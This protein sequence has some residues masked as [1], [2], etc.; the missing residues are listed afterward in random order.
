VIVPIFDGTKALSA[1]MRSWLEESFPSLLD[2][3]TPTGNLPDRNDADV[4]IA[5]NKWWFLPEKETKGKAGAL[6]DK[7]SLR[8]LLLNTLE[9]NRPSRSAAAVATPATKASEEEKSFYSFPVFDQLDKSLDKLSKFIYQDYVSKENKVREEAKENVE[10]DEEETKEKLD[11]IEASSSTSEPSSGSYSGER[12]SNTTTNNNFM[13]FPKLM[14]NNN[15]IPVEFNDDAP[16]LLQCDSLLSELSSLHY[17]DL[18]QSITDLVFPDRSSGTNTP[19]DGSSE[20]D[21]KE[22]QNKKPMY[23]A[24]DCYEVRNHKKEI[25]S[26]NSDEIISFYLCPIVKKSNHRKHNSHQW[27]FDAICEGLQDKVTYAFLTDCGTSFDEKCV[28]RLMLELFSMPDLIGVTAR[29]RVEIPNRYF[30]PCIEAPYEFMKGQHELLSAPC[31]KCWTT[32]LLSPCPLQ[33]IEFE[34]SVTI[35]LAMFNLVEA[36]PVMPGPCQLMHWQKMKEYNV[37]DE[38]F[39]LLFEGENEKKVLPPLPPSLKPMRLPSDLEKLLKKMEEGNLT[40]PHSPARTGALPCSTSSLS[41]DL[42]DSPKREMKGSSSFLKSFS[43]GN[44]SLYNMLNNTISSPTGK[45]HEMKDDI[46]KSKATLTFAEFLRVNMRLAEDRILTF[47]SI[48]S[49]GHGTK[50]VL[51]STFYYQPEIQWN[52]LLTQ[53]R[54]WTNGTFAGFLFSFVSPRARTRIHGGMFDPHKPGKNMRAIYG[55]WSLQLVILCYLFISPAIFGA[56]VYKSLN[57]LGYTWPEMFSWVLTPLFGSVRLVEFFSF[58]YLSI[59]AAWSL[60]SFYADRGKIPEYLCQ[61]LA[62]YCCLSMLPMYISIWRSIV[63][64]GFNLIGVLVLINLFI[65]V[66][67]SVGED[68]RS[69]L[70]YLLYLPWL[71]TLIMFFIVFFPAYSFARLW[72]TTWGNRATGK[73]SALNDSMENFMKS[74]NLQFVLFL[75]GINIFFLWAF[76][77]IFSLGYAAIV[78]FMLIALF[79]ILIQLAA[80]CVFLFVVHP[81]RRY[82][83]KTEDYNKGPRQPER[84]NNEAPPLG[85][86]NKGKLSPERNTNLSALAKLELTTD[87]TQEGEEEVNR[88]TP[89]PSQGLPDICDTSLYSSVSEDFSIDLKGKVKEFKSYPSKQDQLMGLLRPAPPASSKKLPFPDYVNNDSGDKIISSGFSASLDD[90]NLST[91]CESIFDSREENMIVSN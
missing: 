91:T 3:L 23:Q 33:G 2:E 89:S 12:A 20:Q 41:L 86:R 25:I 27:F 24:D 16:P 18:E 28:S 70:L 15:P 44:L 62:I 43:S 46:D 63:L 39:N 60:G 37:V 6:N 71:L 49:T 29:Q 42:S 85:R 1:S 4:R 10:E 14:S 75:I 83:L 40:T 65:P 90:Y 81:L 11:S 59:Y 76:V 72:D 66:V 19:R 53:R 45:T 48:F 22:K 57:L 84:N 64:E 17:I 47:V 9:A 26:P 80:S 36:L 13:S 31:W 54:R 50:W 7:Q 73:D 21:I 87:V 5:C 74:K 69:S 34:G 52:S 32:F 68:I 56:G 38:Y 88:K 61:T 30:H 82:F 78:A 35:S 58:L 8:T 67:I 51:G 79:P 55:L 77:Q